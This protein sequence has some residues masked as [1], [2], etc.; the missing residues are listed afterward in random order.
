MSIPRRI[1]TPEILAQYEAAFAPPALLPPLVRRPN[2]APAAQPAPVPA[3]LPAM[4]PK[5]REFQYRARAA[6]PPFIPSPQ[7]QAFFDWI[8]DSSGSCL[9]EA[10]A[11][12][13]KTT[14]LVQ[15]L[16]RMNGN[17]FF[18]AYNRK[19][20]DEI[21]TKAEKAGVLRP[22]IY[23]NTMHGAG[24]SA[25]RR[26]CPD[27]RDP[28]DRKMADIVEDMARA[29]GGQLGE[30]IRAMS[31]FICKM[32]SFGKQFLIGC[33]GRKFTDHGP[34][35][36]LVERFGTDQELP[37]DIQL[38][39]A[40]ARTI[41]SY[42]LSIEACRRVI[43]FDDMI[44]APIY[45]GVRMFQNDW[46]LIDERQDTNPARRELA[47]RM[48]KPGGRLVAV[49]DTRQAIYGFTGAD[50]DASKF[51]EDFGCVQMPLTVTYRCPKA[52]VQYVRQWVSHIE[53][54]PDAPE[55]AVRPAIPAKMQACRACLG[56]G[57]TLGH[58]MPCAV[59]GGAKETA[60]K[61]PWFL[62]DRP[63]KAD[64]ILCRYTAPL[65][66]TAFAMLRAG[67]ACK[68]EGRD[69]G[70][71]LKKLASRWKVRSLEALEKRLGQWLTH[72][73]AKAE[74]AGSD[75]KALAARDLSDTLLVFIERCREKGVHSV[76]GLIAEIDLLFADDVKDVL[77]LA[78]G[79]KAKGREWPRVYWL[80][81][82]NRMRL[83]KDWEIVQ[84][85]NIKYV[86]GTRAMAELILVPEAAL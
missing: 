30:R 53:A 7:Q 63:G 85:D 70:N 81:T 5:P 19:I 8:L 12:A 6:Q 23:I 20:A 73:V 45:F 68:V 33:K 28:T 77:T 36:E 79:H 60:D 57:M 54:H 52:V 66:K 51:V 34:W 27:L 55:G 13:G 43:D 17:V 69:I 59:C 4:A 65:I 29:A 2:P 9:L 75:K 42:H 16:S 74:A 14:T 61:Q 32:S 47:K 25:W 24:Y 40:L 3:E 18:G 10:V 1:L 44:F 76:D 83:A 80:Q 39:E 50:G 71:G 46:V 58:G 72:E 22:G 26:A 37:G 21:K 78:T 86:I 56:S 15:S 11:G 62:R 64:A 35:M 31:G 38:D 67:V 49:G 48:L 41:D 84:E 82:A